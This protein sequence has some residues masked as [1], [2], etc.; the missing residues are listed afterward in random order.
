MRVRSVQQG[1]VLVAELPRR[2]ILIL[3]EV[4]FS[5]AELANGT[6]ERVSSDPRALR[7][8]SGDLHGAGSVDRVVLEPPPSVS[9]DDRWTVELDG[10]VAMWSDQGRLLHWDASRRGYVEV[11]DDDVR[12]LDLVREPRGVLELEVLGLKPA[13]ERLAALALLR[14]D[15]TVQFEPEPLLID[16][17][18]QPRHEPLAADCVPG[19]VVTEPVRLV[20]L[21]DDLPDTIGARI[22]VVAYRLAGR[23]RRRLA[24]RRRGAPAVG[25]PPEPAPIPDQPAEADV[26]GTPSGEVAS[27]GS[28]PDGAAPPPGPVAHASESA[29]GSGRTEA[30]SPIED[31]DATGS[32]AKTSDPDP[33]VPVIP[34]YTWGSVSDDQGFA[35][36]IEPSLSIGML[37]AVARQHEGGGLEARYNLQRIRPDADVVFQEWAD[38]PRP[39]VFA[40][41]DYLWNIDRHLDFSRRIK[42]ISPASI[43]LHGGPSV[44]KYEADAEQFFAD[45]PYVDIAARGEGEMTFVEILERLD[46]DLSDGCLDRLSG[47]AGLTFRRSGPDGVELIRTEDRPRM[48]SLEGLPSPYL[49]GEFDDLLG[50]PWRSASVESNRGCPYGCTYCDWGSATLARIRKFELERV[51]DEL[52]WIMLN[53]AP[54]ELHVADANFGIFARDVEIAQT[55]ADLRGRLG[56]PHALTISLAKN[57]VRYSQQIIQILVQ[58]GVSPITASSAVQTMDEHTL[59]VIQRQNIKLE[60]YDDLAVTFA[61]QGIPLVTDLLMGLPGAT[62]DSFKNDLQHC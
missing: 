54:S 8:L 25:P 40:F 59:Q 12:V 15:R 35:E 29:L 42:E 9:L 20:P 43:C 5:V 10:P 21:L 3:D 19:Q 17:V 55:V 22:H 32:G 36:M 11:R 31:R 58:A 57:T 30:T 24:D 61:E 47:V 48:A 18:E 49:T 60:K 4:G 38:D 51:Q 13:I 27:A 16:P 28:R 33:R 41:S 44:P 37:F 52:E 50:V 26:V 53:A 23:V 2:R 62:V 56:A 7:E 1:G 46:G 39:A 45:H 34:L 6:V 14:V